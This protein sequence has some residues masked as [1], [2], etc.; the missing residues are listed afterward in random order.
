MVKEA[1]AQSERDRERKELAEARNLADHTV[2]SSEKAIRDFGDRISLEDRQNLGDAVDRLKKTKEGER[3]DEI[4]KAA[5]A[6]NQTL[7]DVSKKLYEAASGAGGPAP[8]AGSEKPAGDN[9][10]DAEF[11][12][13]P[14]D[15]KAG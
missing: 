5:E 11:R 9:V 13:K 1:E 6:L 12:P 10:V 3:A 8:G 15:R 4:R 2:Y 14:E 7:H